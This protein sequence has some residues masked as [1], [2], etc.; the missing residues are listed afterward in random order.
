[1]FPFQTLLYYKYTTIPHPE[2]FAAQH[3]AFCEKTAV[4]GRIIVA[5][6]GLNAPLAE[7]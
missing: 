6:E 3:L 5:H 1:M 7:P 2:E 4:L